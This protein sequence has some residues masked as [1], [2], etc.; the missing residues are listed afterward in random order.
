M[1]VA[2]GGL[3]QETNS[4]SPVATTL[5]DFEAEYLLRDAEIPEYFAG[6]NTEIAGFLAACESLADVHATPLLAAA[7]NSG[8]NVTAETLERLSGE[9][10]DR[11]SRVMSEAPLDVL[12]LALHGSMC[13]DGEDDPEG[14]LL[15]SCRSAV[16]SECVIAASLDLHANV[17]ERMAHAANVLVGYRT[18]PH[19]DQARTAQR[20]ASVAMA[21]A[22][23]PPVRTLVQKLPLIVQAE[24]MQT[25]DGPMHEL[26][27]KADLLEAEGVAA[28]VSVFGVQPWLDVAGAGCSVVVVG[29]D[30]DVARVHA[31]HLAGEF[32]RRRDRFAVELVGVELAIQTA[33]ETEDGP[34][35]LVDSADSPSSGAPG[36]SAVVLAALLNC[37]ETDADLGGPC[38]LTI[39]DPE[40]AAAAH[41]AGVGEQIEVTVGGRLDPTRSKGVRFAGR[42]ERLTDGSFVRKGPAFT[43]LP[44]DA[45]PTAVLT[46]GSIRVL[47]TTRPVPTSDPELFRSAGL[48][49]EKAK[50]VSVKSPTLFRAAYDR[51]SRRIIYVDT[52]GA[53]SANLRQ[54]PWQ[55]I[56]R[57]IY[58]LDDIDWEP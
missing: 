1:R 6:T 37:V 39:V 10:L 47:V 40:A 52:P 42:V 54:F 58:P 16:G 55:N 57:P 5:A 18:Y 51:F 4:F 49:P 7:A 13:V 45:G 53:A 20:V 29:R 48:E 26:R 14:A 33:L 11:L 21:A 2:I 35:V 23:G 25:T 36:D 24:H 3:M 38:L 32:W 9:L 28:A 43:G 30:E 8:G 56:S 27:A 15:D 41:R 46:A 34:V 17:T 19:V 50:I 44:L 31:R 12:L 22:A